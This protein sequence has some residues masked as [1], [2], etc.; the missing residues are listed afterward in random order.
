MPV[1]YVGSDKKKDDDQLRL[2]RA[3]DWVTDAGPVR[4][5]GQRTFLI[6]QEDKPILTLKG[7]TFNS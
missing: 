2:G 3:T 6:G 7:I 1:L 4:G 5:L